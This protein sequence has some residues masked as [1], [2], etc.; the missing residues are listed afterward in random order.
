MPTEA[1]KRAVRTATVAGGVA[2][3]LGAGAGIVAVGAIAAI[4]SGVLELE[5][6]P[7]KPPLSE[8]LWARSFDNNGVIANWRAILEHVMD[9]VSAL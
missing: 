8:A 6:G 5:R 4:A 3:A 2:L 9:G 1:Q 7:R